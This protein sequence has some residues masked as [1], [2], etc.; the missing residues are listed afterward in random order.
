MSKQSF[1]STAM[2][3]TTVEGI[4]F[5]KKTVTRFGYGLPRVHKTLTFITANVWTGV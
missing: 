4:I 5:V 2:D 1:T 3:I